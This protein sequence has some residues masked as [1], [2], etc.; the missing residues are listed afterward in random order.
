MH[1]GVED[2]GTRKMGAVDQHRA[3][4]TDVARIDVRDFKRHVGAV[5]A[6]EDQRER[7]RVADPEEH[8]RGQPIR[9]GRDARSRHALARQLRADEARSEGHTAELQSLMRTY[10]DAFWF[11]KNNNT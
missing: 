4:R 10:Y 5:L 9:I 11:K 7:V 1:A 2:V 6:V 3:G 8:Q